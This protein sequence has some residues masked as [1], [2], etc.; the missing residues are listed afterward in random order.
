MA[1]TYTVSNHFKQ[2]LNL[3]NITFDADDFKAIL[4][5]TTFTFDPDTHATLADV[6]ADQLVTGGGYT[7]DTKALTGV[8]VTEDDVNNKSAVT[9]DNVTW[10]ATTGGIPSTGAYIIYDDTTSDDTV[11]WCVD[12]GTDYAVPDTFSIQIQDIAYSTT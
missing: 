5:N 3:G 11:C 6:T 8:S 1:A 7:Q 10:T 12:F 9:W 2:Q 4:M